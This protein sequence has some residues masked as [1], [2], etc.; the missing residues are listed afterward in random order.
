M[1]FYLQL[2]KNNILKHNTV[3]ELYCFGDGGSTLIPII[4]EK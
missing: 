3:P 2:F 4:T 1:L